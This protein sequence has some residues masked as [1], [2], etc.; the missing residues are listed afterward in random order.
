MKNVKRTGWALALAGACLSPLA[1]ADCGGF[2]AWQS[3]KIYVANNVVSHKQVIYEAKWWTR[4]EEPGTTGQ[5]GV[6]RTRSACPAPSATPTPTL[7]PSP[8]PTATA[9]P[10]PSPTPS[11]MPTATPRPSATPTVTPTAT[12]TP[13]PSATPTATPT[14]AATATP[15]PSATP[16]ATPTSSPTPTVTPT[17]LTA[18]PD[19]NDPAYR[20]T[21]ASPVFDS[22]RNWPSGFTVHVPVGAPV[23]DPQLRVSDIEDGDLSA[24]I[25]Q[26]AGYNPAVSG[27]YTLAYT[28]RDNGHADVGAY[29]SN[30]SLN[31]V[32]YDPLQP[33]T[34]PIPLPRLWPAELQ[35]AALVRSAGQSFSRVIKIDGAQLPWPTQQLA[36]KSLTVKETQWGGSARQFRLQISDVAAGAI[37]YSDAT[38]L[39]SGK[40]LTLTAPVTL[41]TGRDYR[42]T[43]FYDAGNPQ[44]LAGTGTGELWLEAA[45][46][47]LKPVYPYADISAAAGNRLAWDPGLAAP[48]KAKL[49][50]AD[51]SSETLRVRKLLNGPALSYRL[52]NPALA[53]LRVEAQANGDELL[54]LTGRNAGETVL[55][56]WANGALVDVVQLVVARPKT[57]TLSYSYIRHPSEAVTHMLSDGP[58]IMQ[59]I[60][61]FYVPYL[62]D[63]QWVNQGVIVYNWDANGNLNNDSEEKAL[64]LQN[65]AIPGAAAVFSNVFTMRQN[66]ISSSGGSNGGGSSIGMGAADGPVRAAYRGTTPDNYPFN[67]AVTLTHELGHNL[68]LSHYEIGSANRDGNFMAINKVDPA[69]YAFQW[70][71]MHATLEARLAAGDPGIAAR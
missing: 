48:L 66:L 4:G 44:G 12:A 60:A 65:G 50:A 7:K 29:T 39:Q 70:S 5:W 53:D 71:T 63:V 41:Q 20:L 42:V 21:N 14:P 6:W 37:V 9:T 17:P 43:L 46:E 32:V 49:L 1:L 8:T 61:A 3:G 55:E 62:V 51:G 31:V 27:A 58:A 47:L 52:R 28:V 26:T 33:P 23:L 25:V 30:Y 40:T 56:A 19:L 15:K 69:F 54:V 35:S 57:V 64:A 34:Q 2:A 36:L 11:A 22:G 18:S 68:G 45:G 67:S 38:T 13:K 10:K 59:Q 16:T 24:R